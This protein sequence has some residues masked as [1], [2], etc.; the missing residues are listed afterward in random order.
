VILMADACHAGAATRENKR[1]DGSSVWNP[2]ELTRAFAGWETGVVV[3]MA[4]LGREFSVENSA[5][6][7]GAFTK[8][9]VD[10]IRGA[11]AAAY[12]KDD[13]LY[14]SELTTYV[15]RTVPKLTNNSQH[16]T[17]H[18]P[19]TVPDYPIAVLK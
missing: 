8:A 10:G 5:W 1:R 16:P 2:E 15:Q 19:E 13:I 14:L 9:L 18:K 3:F 17:I 12:E 7:H 4:S 6:G 11:A